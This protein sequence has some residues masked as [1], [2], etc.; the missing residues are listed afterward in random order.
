MKILKQFLVEKNYPINITLKELYD[1]TNIE[2][3]MYTTNLNAEYK[4]TNIFFESKKKP[5]VCEI[6][7]LI[8]DSYE[9]FFLDLK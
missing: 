1:Y 9:K 4:S 6:I 8:T 3:H 2:L 5:T 7:N